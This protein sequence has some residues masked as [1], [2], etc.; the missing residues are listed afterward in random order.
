MTGDTIKLYSYWR[1]SACYRVRIA[2][3]LKG[4]PFQTIPVHLVRNGGEQ[5]TE[6]FKVLNPQEM[7]PVLMH[8]GRMLRQS[9]AIIDYLDEIWTSNLLVPSTARDR[10]RVRAISE[11]I[12]CDIHPLGN[13]RVLQYL[14]SHFGADPAARDEWSRHWIRAGF[15]ALEKVLE[16]NPSTGAYCEGDVP[17][18]ADCCL[19]PQAYNAVRVGV[20][21][22]EFPLIKRIN[23]TCLALPAFDNAR[24]EKQ[25]DAPATT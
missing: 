24:P 25:P 13:L 23:D 19:V 12:A 16:D 22:G 5:H 15:E 21:L 2:L 18:L 8:G 10:Q 9:M 3:N 7:I 14:E 20:D 11:M 17:T 6:A 1:S 4:L